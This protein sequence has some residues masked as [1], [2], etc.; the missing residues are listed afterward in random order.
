MPVLKQTVHKAVE[1]WLSRAL[2]EGSSSFPVSPAVTV[3]AAGQC[4]QIFQSF[5]KN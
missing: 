3:Q 5:K 2:S 1:N 4:G